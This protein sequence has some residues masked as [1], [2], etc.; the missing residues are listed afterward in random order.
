M[1]R[2]DS[3]SSSSKANDQS[4]NGWRSRSRR[5]RLGLNIRSDAMILRN[6]LEKHEIRR[7][8]GANAAL[9]DPA[10]DGPLRESQSTPTPSSSSRHSVANFSSNRVSEQPAVVTS[11]SN[12]VPRS[13]GQ[14][15]ESFHDPNSGCVSTEATA[16]SH[17]APT[18]LC[19][20]VLGAPG[21]HEPP[22]MSSVSVTQN[23]FS[24]RVSLE[25]P[26]INFLPKEIANEF[27]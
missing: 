17:V 16:G 13:T 4:L 25:I 18:I 8:F 14:S 23:L 3:C 7:H 12:R 21:Y 11:I 24:A 15:I 27:Q 6:M 2:P 22:L 5:L 9:R 26:K 19:S 10:R 20:D 1:C